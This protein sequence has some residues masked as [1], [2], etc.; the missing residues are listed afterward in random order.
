LNKT[1]LIK[2]VAAVSGKT[3]KDTEE[4][5][6]AILEVITKTL[7]DGEKIKLTGFGQ[8]EVKERKA[9]IGRN[10]KTNEEIPIPATK[11]PV[12]TPGKLLK[13]AVVK[14]G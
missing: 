1:Q 5:I 2:K 14:N 9:R 12:F 4:I 13:D 6:D 7:V 10:P 3:Q 11:K 8:F